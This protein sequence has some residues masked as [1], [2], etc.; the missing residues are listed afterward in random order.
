MYVKIQINVKQFERVLKIRHFL[1]K[2]GRPYSS[3]DITRLFICDKLI[4]MD[5][6]IV[7]SRGI[8]TT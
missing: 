2:T 6:K 3:N 7:C 5:R 4:S 1:Q 8:K